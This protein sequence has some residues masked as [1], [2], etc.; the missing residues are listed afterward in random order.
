MTVAKAYRLLHAIFETAAEDRIVSRNPCR[1][2]GAGKEE[3]D[4]RAIVPLPIVFKLAETVPVRYR[5]LILLATFADMRW[6]EPVGLRRE[7]IDL[8]ACE[9]RITETLAQLDKGGLRPDTPKSRAGRRVV[10]SRPRSPRRSAGTWNGSLSRGTG[11]SSSSGRRAA[12]YAARTSTG[13][14]TRPGPRS[15]CRVF[16][17]T[18]SGTR[19]APCRP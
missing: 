2:A 9:I 7:N 19:A 13:P 15:A 16:I 5:T 17:S 3:S 4:E 18:I 12:S 8:D 10:G 14:G 6:G 11:G 1:I